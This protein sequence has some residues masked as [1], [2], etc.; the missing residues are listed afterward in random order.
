MKG[1]QTVLV[2]PAGAD[3]TAGSKAA[4]DSGP[5]VFNFD[6]SY[7]SFAKSDP[8]YGASAK[9]ILCTRVALTDIHSGPGEPF[10]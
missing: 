9:E 4:K 1:S 8:N 7:W 10:R 3:K 5:K 2:P 6:R